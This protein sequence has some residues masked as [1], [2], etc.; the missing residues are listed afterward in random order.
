MREQQTSHH[1]PMHTLE[2]PGADKRTLSDTSVLTV[3]DERWFTPET[4]DTSADGRPSSS[5]TSVTNA[6]TCAVAA[7]ACTQFY[8]PGV[9][10]RAFHCA[11]AIDR[12]VYVFGGHL[13]HKEKKGLHK[14][15]DVWRLDTV[16]GAGWRCH[17]AH[18]RG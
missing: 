8:T 11:A 13:F 18:P 2:R 6:R 12:S 9:P 14:F 5:A 17:Q 16:G 4:P 3:S 10:L 1:H 7:P 15:N